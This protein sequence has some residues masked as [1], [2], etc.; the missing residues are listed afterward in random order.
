[1]KRRPEYTTP[2]VIVGN[3]G[4]CDAMPESFWKRT[5]VAF[6][7]TNRCLAMT[8][9]V[10]VQWSALVMRDR[11][12]SLFREG[13]NVQGGW[14]YHDELWKDHPAWRVGSAH[15]RCTYSDEYVRQEGRWQLTADYD[16][17]NHEAAVMKNSS[18]VLMAANWAWINGAR[19][20][21]LIGVDYR[22]PH[23]AVMY[24]PWASLKQGD[25]K[26]YDRPVPSGIEKQFRRSVAAIREAGGSIVN[27]SPGT[28]L[29][30]V[31][32]GEG[33]IRQ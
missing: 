4:S 16:Q 18:V 28:A 12:H 11:Y 25:D 30:A 5:D 26:Q 6:V 27:L 22:T 20:L 24:E 33:I 23:H 14:K 19:D 8:A 29:Q 1:M 13:S 15:D 7:G 10:G 32:I 21:R 2:V 9:C 31:P 3:G 17:G